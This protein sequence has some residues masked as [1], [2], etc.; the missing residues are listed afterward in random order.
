MPDGHPMGERSVRQLVH[1]GTEQ[2]S[3]LVRQEMTLAKLELTDKGRR[4]GRGG[5]MLG[6]S[7][8]LAYIGF[9][10][11]AAAAAA[12]LVL[13]LPV[14]A[15]ALTVAFGLLLIAGLLGIIGR[16][17]LRRAVPPGPKEALGSVRADVE[18]IK[19]R[20]HHR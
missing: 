3:Q 19:E 16:A 5:G 1:D 6:A 15:A 8:A 14:W 20:A 18:E 17:Q 4:M 9:F 2:L 11:F 13:L 12:A 10:A 7:G